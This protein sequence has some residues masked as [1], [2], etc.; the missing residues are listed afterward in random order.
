[1]NE[2]ENDID[3]NKQAVALHYDG[4][5]APTVTAKGRGLVADE[6][7]KVARENDVPIK[8]QSD[9]VYFLSKVD[10]GAEIPE[11]LYLAAAEVIAF[12]YHLKHK[13]PPEV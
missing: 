6:I 8:E 3:L 7:L 2:K 12:A 11:T 9:L 10:L 1:M 13:T 4:K 5:K